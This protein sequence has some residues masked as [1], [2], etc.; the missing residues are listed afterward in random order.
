MKITL[1]QNGLVTGKTFRFNN[2][3]NQEKDANTPVGLM[4]EEG[5]YGQSAQYSA[6]ILG[7]GVLIPE[8]ADNPQVLQGLAFS[9]VI[10]DGGVDY[11][12][13]GRMANKV[14]HGYSPLDGFGFVNAQAATTGTLPT[15]GVVSRRVH[16]GAGAFDIPLP[17]NG[18][19]GIECRTPG[20]NGGYQLV[21]TFDRPVANAGS[22]AIQGSATQAPANGGQANPSIAANPNQVVVNLE[23]VAN[24]QHLMV[25][26]SDVR[27]TSGNALNPVTARMDVLI[28]DVNASGRADNGDA[29][30]VRNGAGAIPTDTASARVDINC[31]GRV[32]NGDAIVIR[33]N[34]GVTLP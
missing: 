10:T 11:P 2:G 8:Y 34:P 17:F 20:P 26:L 6:D 12:F 23:N 24:A 32:D 16:G 27:D 29:I 3:R 21:F 9:G 5:L 13:T 28:G 14:G 4:V 7:S 22:V 19:A 25:T 31:S 33:N 30:V 1:P 18:P 15:P